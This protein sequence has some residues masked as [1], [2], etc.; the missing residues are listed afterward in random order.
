MKCGETFYKPKF[1]TNKR[2]KRII[3]G[4]D[5]VNHS[6]PFLATV[7]ILLN[8]ESEHHC[9]G[10]IIS[11]RHILTA[12]H[13]IFVY[14]ELA[15]QLEMDLIEMMSLMKVNLGIFDHTK[16]DE[17]EYSVVDFYIHEDF[18]YSDWTVSND[19]MILIL[20]RPIDFESKNVFILII[21]ILMK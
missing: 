14:I 12:A 19:L 15:N 20:D 7:R 5:A 6:W 11:G 1:S 17:N 4:E 21:F 18:N 3:G 16:S 10:T 2:I 8:G 13:C 9:G